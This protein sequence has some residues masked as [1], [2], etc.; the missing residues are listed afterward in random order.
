MRKYI[1]IKLILVSS[2]V[3][4]A[5]VHVR[6]EPRHHNVFE[7]EYLRILDVY[8]APKDTTQYH[9]HNTPSI[10]I[11]LAHCKVSSQMPGGQSQPGANLF[12]TISYDSLN[13]PRIHRVWNEDT[14]WF[15]VMDIELTAKTQKG[16]IAVLQNQFLKLLFNEKQVN[17]YSF[18]L[19]SVNNLQLPASSNGYL[20]VCLNT[21]S[22]DLKIDNITQHRSVKAG[23]YEWIEQGK[24]VSLSKNAD[25][26]KFVLLEL[27]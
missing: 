18:E 13:K 20:L 19:N 27:K 6:D 3:S 25:S 1:F 21:S 22:I 7:N 23:H 5:Q 14:G 10:F 12:G 17:G 4:S 2:I 8:L 9:L 24:T 15:H 16:N 26:G 11:I